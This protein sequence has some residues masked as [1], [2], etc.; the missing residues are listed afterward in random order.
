MNFGGYMRK[1]TWFSVLM[2]LLLIFPAG[3]VYAATF[4]DNFD[5]QDAS[6]WNA[7]WPDWEVI[8]IKGED[9]SYGYHGVYDDTYP[10][11]EVAASM[12]DNGA[13][14]A[15]SGLI[16]ETRV[17]VDDGYSGGI[18]FSTNGFGT[19]TFDGYSL[20][21]DIDDNQISL[22]QI[23]AEGSLASAPVTGGTDYGTFY[24]LRLEID[25]NEY[26]NA[27]LYNDSHELLASLTDIA[28]TITNVHSGLVG[29]Y[30]D[31]E[32]T[33]DYYSLTGTPVPIPGA[34]WLFGSGLI[35][36]V[37]LKR[38]SMQR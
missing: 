27:Y 17:K 5:S 32:G 19:E 24:I 1:A 21:V 36:L 11:A 25:S 30:A 3:Q 26:M 16:I 7:V 8:P 2:F 20:G 15:T 13:S 28:P 37:G 18:F 9:P 6:G 23:A 22:N 4:Y 34:I 38:R 33:F 35:G 10:D 29:V 14:Y 31:L 12:A